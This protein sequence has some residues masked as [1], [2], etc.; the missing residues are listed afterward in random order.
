MRNTTIAAALGALLLGCLLQLSPAAA[1][2][3]GATTTVN[4]LQV[5]DTKVGSGMV[6][7]PMNIVEVHYTGW[8]YDATVA[9]HKG[10]RFDSSLDRNDPFQFQVAAGQVIPGWDQGLVGMKVGGKRT[11]VIPAAM[12]YGSRGAGGVIPPGATLL[13]E[14]ELLE[15]K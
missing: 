7:Y 2:D 5:T 10:K 4:D 9:N 13:F 14:I 12:A 1:A 15:I 6:V 3:K 8:L 11:L